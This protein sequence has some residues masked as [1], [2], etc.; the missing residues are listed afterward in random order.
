MFMHM[1]AYGL[2][3]GNPI[4]GKEILHRGNVLIIA[5]EETMNEIDLRLSACKQKMGKNDNKFK[6]YK[7][8]L[9]NDL[10]LVKFTKD[11]AVKTKQYKQ[12]ENVIKS[13]ILNLYY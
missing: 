11:A 5:A 7:R 4:F 8:G 6:I 10:K 1:M 2:A 12:L 13:K 9:E 3:T